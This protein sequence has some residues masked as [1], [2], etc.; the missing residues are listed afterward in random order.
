[1]RVTFHCY[2]PLH[3]ASSRRPHVNL[4]ADD[5]YP[6]GAMP[7]ATPNKSPMKPK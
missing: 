7:K 5:L 6:T 3:G 4:A 2:L 1:M